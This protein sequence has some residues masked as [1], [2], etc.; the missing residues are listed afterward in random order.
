MKKVKVSKAV[1][2]ICQALANDEKSLTI[3]ANEIYGAGKNIR[4]KKNEKKKSKLQS[5]RT[6]SK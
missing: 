3:L 1:K 2:I 4:R 6:R 5:R